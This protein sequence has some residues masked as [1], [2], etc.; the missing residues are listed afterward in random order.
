MD[1]FYCSRCNKETEDALMMGCEHNLCLMC[2]A[3][4]LKAQNI[5][6]TNINQCIKCEICNTFTEL[7]P[8]TVMDIFKRENENLEEQVNYMDANNNQNYNFNNNKGYMNIEE[9]NNNGENEESQNKNNKINE[10]KNINNNKNIEDNNNISTSEINIINELSPNNIKQLCKEHSEPLTYLCLDCMSNCVCAECVVHGIHK[11]HE[12]LNIRKA[13]P[14]IYKKLEDLSK[15]AN[16]QKKSIFLVNEA[17][18]KKKKLVN[19]LIERCKNEIHNTFEQI[20]LRLDNK[21]KEI[22]NNTTSILYKNIEELNNYDILLKQNSDTVEELIGK[23][24]NILRKKDELST[25]N[26]FCENRN[27]ILKQCDL[28]ELNNLPDLDSFTNFKIEPNRFT[29]NNMF[30]GINN[31]NFDI[32]NIKGIATN[33]KKKNKSNKKILKSQFTQPNYDIMNNN[34]NQYQNINNNNNN[35]YSM[36]NKMSNPNIINT[37]SN[38]IPGNNNFKKERPRTAKSH[39]RRRKKNNVM[40]INNIQNYPNNLN[41]NIDYFQNDF[42]QNF[43]NNGMF[44]INFQ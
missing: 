3:Q 24:N 19:T 32:T 36:L 10:N 8:E 33:N 22:I 40:Q 13:Y 11:N 2:S 1:T 30:E 12:V 41:Q 17:I 37:F 35:N 39:T 34:I 15:Y 38:Q 20:K 9:L 5:K 4:I 7:D 18:S 28:N 44:D 23:I 6:N 25:I 29:L 31:F 14:L 27:K 42:N 21:E 26:Y 43:D 16:D